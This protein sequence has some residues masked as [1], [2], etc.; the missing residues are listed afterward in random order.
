[1][2]ERCRV[3]GSSVLT[4]HSLSSSRPGIASIAAMIS[5]YGGWVR[6]ACLA[7]LRTLENVFDA[8]VVVAQAYISGTGWGCPDG[9]PCARFDACPP[10]DRLTITKSDCDTWCLCRRQVNCSKEFRRCRSKP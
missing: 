6:S 3:I 5:A 8:N 4:I 7:T 2:N 1:M 10:Y 9:A